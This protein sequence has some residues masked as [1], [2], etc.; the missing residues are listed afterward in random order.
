MIFLRRLL[1]LAISEKV[2][3]KAPDAP[4]IEDVICRA[5]F[6]ET[7]SVRANWFGKPLVLNA[8]GAVIGLPTE[9][10]AYWEKLEDKA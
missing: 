3:I 9:W 8:D 4:H 5:R 6:S 2:I 10:N 7:I 1:A